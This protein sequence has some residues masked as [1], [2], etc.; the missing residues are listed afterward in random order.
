[1]KSLKKVTSELVN[2][3]V[4]DYAPIH[5]IGSIQPHGVLLA[6][7][8]SNLTIC[9]VSEN[10]QEYLRVSPEFLLGQSITHIF[11]DATVQHITSLLQNNEL[12]TANP[13][14]V[15]LAQPFD[16]AAE[17]A[18]YL[19]T[20]YITNEIMVLEL[21]PMLA[22]E[23]TQPNHFYDCLRPA[24]LNIKRAPSLT[25]LFQQVAQD[26][27]KLSE[28]D[29]VMIYRFDTDH[30]GIVV[31]EAVRPDLESY[32]GLHYP[33]ADV[34][35]AARRLFTR[36]WLRTIPDVNAVPV[37][38][39]ALDNTEEP[40]D[41][42]QSG[43]RGV[44]PCHLE[45]LRNMGVAASMSIPIIDQ[46]QL[47]GLIACH[48]YTPKLASYKARRMCE[49]LGQLVSV[50]FVLQQERELHHY[51]EQIR[52][53][54][55]QFRQDLVKYPD[56]IE[57]VLRR[58]Q[59]ALLNLVQAQGMAIALGEQ[60]ILVG[61]TPSKTQI[62]DLFVWLSATKQEVFHT[63]SL[64]EHYPDAEPFKDRGSGILA[65]SISVRQMA[66]HIVWF[67]PEKRYTVNWAG[68]PNDA[69][70]ISQEGIVRL[71]PR[72]SFEL[73]KELVCDHSLPWQPLEIE[74]VQELRHSLLIAALESSQI[75][76]QKVAVQAE[77]ANQAKSEFLANMSH[78]IRTPMNAILGFTQLLEVTALTS[79]Q[80]QYLQ[81][82]TRSG[83]NLLAIIN[84]ILDLSR[85]EAGE[86]QANSTKFAPRAVVQ[87]LIQLFQPQADEK[88]L[89]LGVAIATNVPQW[90][91]GPVDRLQQV[92]TNLIRNAIKFTVVGQVILRVECK[93]SSED[94]TVTLHFS[95][96][97]TGIGLAPEDQS[98]IFESFTQ[99]ETATTRKYEG[100]GLGLAICRKLVQL[101]G[102]V[103]GVK[104]TLGQGSNFWFTA[105]LQQ[106]QPNEDTNQAQTMT[107]A[108]TTSIA[109][110]TRIL[111]VED[112]CPNQILAVRM[113]HALGYQA[114][115]VN[116]GQE[117][118]DQF[119]KRRY[120]I[121]LMDCQMPVMDG[122]TATQ[123]LRQHYHAQHQ[124]V[125]IGVT[126]YAMVGDQ[127]K[128]LAAGMDDYLSKP[129]K[130][131]ELNN[132]LEKWSQVVEQR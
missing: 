73:W 85:L 32:L 116:N 90:L 13:F 92:L 31:A 128:C 16:N 131:N 88:G 56:R 33:A 54:E 97:D 99:V 98:R 53:I 30:S 28:F 127:E 120:D 122:Y 11:S 125:V 26:V 81:L 61:E 1:M 34:P 63:D 46:N 51:L 76:L 69:V 47:W 119:A 124:P 7:Q 132:L 66:Y 83:E 129:I 3:A 107:T 105:V 17:K 126:A 108:P 43:L 52:Q 100:T 70:S 110:L 103:I 58:N 23:E 114:D 130:M 44:S 38:L 75:A 104:S 20:A 15:A 55:R 42:S 112:S 24:I 93:P 102:G 37:K 22:V 71:S 68:N 35:L 29:R 86:L 67:R 6:L 14:S 10:S 2:R 87:D 57:T 96:Q 21:E 91:I 123:Q 109:K 39:L 59:K 45:Y 65:A 12:E 82:I 84:D 8:V 25:H 27:R 118:L 94:S 74:A 77:K 4:D 117:A 79:E 5:I 106:P 101:M 89:F 49:L 18:V 111:V 41:L 60:I 19:A 80:R 9:Q 48:H 64:V 72:G 121:I 115:V 95:V 78:E 36:K 62:Q 113:L 50:E 40:L